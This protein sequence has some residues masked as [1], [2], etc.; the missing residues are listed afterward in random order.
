MSVRFIES[1][2]FIVIALFRGAGFLGVGFFAFMTV[3]AFSFSGFCGAAGWFGLV[4]IGL[5]WFTA[6]LF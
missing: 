4:R 1:G 5:S 3:A 2:I 6:N